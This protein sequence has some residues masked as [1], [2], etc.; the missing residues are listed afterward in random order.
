MSE[1]TVYTVITFSPVQGFI[2]RS[3]KLRDLYGSSYILSYLARTLCLVLEKKYRWHVV[4][5]AAPNVTQGMPNQI[6]AKC[7]ATS[8]QLS[9]QDLCSDFDQA[10][11]L[12]V[13]TCREWIETELDI[14]PIKDKT[15]Q[16]WRSYWTREWGLWSKYAWEFFLVLGKPGES[17]SAVRQRLNEHKR[18][19]NWT[20]IN[21]QGESSTLSGADAIAHPSMGRKI[22]PKKTYLNQEDDIQAYFEGLTT[23]LQDEGIIVILSQEN[24]LD[25]GK[26]ETLDQEIQAFYRH[27]IRK[28]GKSF[29]AIHKLR[30]D[31]DDYGSAF[32]DPREE[33]SIPELVKRLITHQ[34][35]INRLLERFNQQQQAQT[36]DLSQAIQELKT[37]IETDLSV[38]SFKEL[39][40]LPQKD[41]NQANQP[42]YWTGWF[43][44][45]GDGASDYLKKLGKQGIEAEDRGTTKFSALMRA[46]GHEFKSTQRHP[47]QR[48]HVSKHLNDKGRVI[49]AGGDDFLGVLYDPAQQLQP[50]IC[51]D[52][53]STFKSKIWDGIDPTQTS[54]SKPIGVSVGFVWAGPKVPQREVLQHCRAAERSAKAGGKDRIAFRIL[55]N[56]G[57]NLEWT[58]P[59]WL[60]EA[61]LMKA[62]RDRSK[63]IGEHANWTH[64]YNDVA[65]LESRYAF[66]G[67]QI[68]VALGLVGLYFGSEFRDL[69]A[70]PQ[71][72]WNQDD[73]DHLR[74]FTGLLGDSQPRTENS[75]SNLRLVCQAIN[76]WV[77][78][79]AKVGF[80]LHREYSTGL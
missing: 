62:Y 72:W 74:L 66:R 61:G 64:L 39:N 71:N 17:I 23:K 35:I 15:H 1:D 58:C 67:D 4:S 54:E 5:P 24:I 78:N 37:E 19:R 3:R 13:D 25:H 33:I 14:K 50:Q 12:I 26:I 42:V 30:G 70:D 63:G 49:Y 6:I 79:L 56:S 10:W 7:T 80:Y 51:L 77:I 60:L 29:A 20:G 32:I 11:T 27:L 45:D 21:W 44:G 38:D 76:D 8:I 31:P 41:T 18:S 36:Q 2:E 75:T 28:L 46:W 59:W 68:D 69:I 73:D 65:V 34:A 53:F 43:V 9:E 40:R 22:N 55:F 52:W 16:G 48:A 57:N 47:T